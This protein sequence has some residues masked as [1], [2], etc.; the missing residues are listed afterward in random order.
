LTVTL[1][2]PAARAAVGEI[3]VGGELELAAGDGRGLAFVNVESRNELAVLDLRGRKV[4]KRIALTGCEGPT[5]VAYLPLAHRLLSTCVNGVAAVTDP[6][7]GKVIGSFPIG[8]GPD[9][10]LYDP[11]RRLAFVPAGKSGELDLFADTAGGVKPAG[12]IATQRG[13]RTGAVD[14]RTGGV[15]LPAADYLT[16]ATPGG[17]PKIKPGSVVALVVKP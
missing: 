1:I 11:Q 17:K 3:P 7:A 15:Y 10:A 6:A 14:P 4:L 9:S 13:A 12:K 2:D 16:P 8:Q 5:G